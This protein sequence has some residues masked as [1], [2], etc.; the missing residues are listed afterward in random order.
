MP[1]CLQQQEEKR[2]MENKEE[3]EAPEDLPMHEILPHAN[4]EK[5]EEDVF[6]IVVCGKTN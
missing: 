1:F 2:E 5:E 6:F 4:D 3:K